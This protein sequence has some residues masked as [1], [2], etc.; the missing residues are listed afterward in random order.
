MT[1]R[2]LTIL[3]FTALLA[4]CTTGGG[5]T[6]DTRTLVLLG[7]VL[8]LEPD[9]DG[10]PRTAV[11]RSGQAN[12]ATVTTHLVDGKPSTVDIAV[13]GTLA[14]GTV[15]PG[16][17]GLKVDQQKTGDAALATTQEGDSFLAALSTGKHHAVGLY[18]VQQGN[19]QFIGLG[20]AGE[21]T[22][23]MPTVGAAD[24]NG[25]VNALL[26]GSVSG[27]QSVG[28][29]L[30]MTAA[31]TPGGGT[32]FGRTSGLA[33]NETD[34]PAGVELG[35]NST[36]ISGNTYAGDSISLLSQSTGLPVGTVTSS[37]YQGAFY[38]PDAA[39]TGG[40][41][42]FAATGVPLSS[43]TQD[44]QAVGAFGLAK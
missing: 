42:Q 9:E 33:D 27:V 7:H 28:G 30:K 22:Q 14:K 4:A 31:F 44:V 11:D 12:S 39:E 21:A 13:A 29:R 8:A 37:N 19:R 20:V 5:T 2:N 26:A 16:A 25:D 34:V 24:Y 1:V 40:T 41:F 36:A 43:G 18:A 3:A 38:G 32:V 35:F 23:T 6:P 15:V 17:T 10:V